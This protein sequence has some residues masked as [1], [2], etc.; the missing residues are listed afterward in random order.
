MKH[1]LILA[2]TVL[3]FSIAKA[4]EPGEAVAP[5][6]VP[7]TPIRQRVIPSSPALLVMA[8]TQCNHLVAIVALMPDG[9]VVG[10]DKASKVNYKAQIDWANT[11]KHIFVTEAACRV[12]PQDVGK[13]L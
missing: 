13:D 8:T 3:A 10:F 9:R 6:R 4:A 12:S 7:E 11:A 2:A 1:Y 5:A